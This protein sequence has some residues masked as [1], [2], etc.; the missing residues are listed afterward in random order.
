MAGLHRSTRLDAS[1]EALESHTRVLDQ[2]ESLQLPFQRLHPIDAAREDDTS[3]SQHGSGGHSDD[4]STKAIEEDLRS[5]H[6]VRSKI[7]PFKTIPQSEPGDPPDGGYIAWLHVLAG[8]FT[9]F[10]TWGFIASFG[11]FQTYYEDSLHASPSTISWIGTSQIFCLLFV[12]A[13]SG[14]ASD[15]GFVHEA[16]LLGTSLILLG[17]FMTSF[18]TEYY[19]FFLAQGVCMGI[20]MGVLFVPGLSVPSSYFKRRKSIAV[21]LIVAGSGSGGLVYPAMLQ[22]LLPRIG[23]SPAIVASRSSSLL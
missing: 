23:M 10:I 8:H 5:Q 22:Q 16:V 18:A 21:A 14:R 19:Q 17:T 4:R 9:F 12:G 20:G 3:G 11:V 13:F 2:S 6:R 1:K 7:I 15:A